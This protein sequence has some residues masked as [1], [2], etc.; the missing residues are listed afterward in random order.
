MTT[1]R[2]AEVGSDDD[3]PI[4]LSLRLDDE[5]D[6]VVVRVARD[7]L[8]PVAQNPQ[9]F[10]DDIAAQESPSAEAYPWPWTEPWRP[11]ARSK[12]EYLACAGRLDYVRGL[13]ARAPQG[14]ENTNLLALPNAG[15]LLD[16]GVCWW[17]SRM[18]RNAFYLAYFEP[19][20]ERPT[21]KEARSIVAG[22]MFPR[23]VV[24]IPGFPDLRAFSAEHRQVVQ[25]RLE[26][27]QILEGLFQFCWVNGL[28]GV[29]ETTPEDMRARMDAIYA[30]VRDEGIAYL[31]L[32][33]PGIDAHAWLVSDMVPIDSGYRLLL[34]DSSS[35]TPYYREYT[36][37]MTHLQMGTSGRA[38]PTLQRIHEL[39]W[40]KKAIADF[41]EENA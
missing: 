7:E 41:V 14:M 37:G 19:E 38:V 1:Y 2:I 6:E 30:Q 16:G 33:M 5:D 18:T 10:V 21:A 40:M 39:R 13:A 34:V 15:G 24:R 36:F 8:L 17:H 29:T 28:A 31:K 4:E 22:L 11:A 26:R 3:E 27:T 20:A 12:A 9:A 23:E 25:Q 35:F 32:Q